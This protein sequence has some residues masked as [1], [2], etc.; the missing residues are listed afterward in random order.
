MNSLWGSRGA[1]PR[2]EHTTKGLVL[3]AK[4]FHSSNSVLLNPQQNL[5]LMCSSENGAPYRDGTGQHLRRG[6]H[7]RILALLHRLQCLKR[8]DEQMLQVSIRIS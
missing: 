5:N 8:K 1:C 4:T 2:R 6:K 3:K 7:F